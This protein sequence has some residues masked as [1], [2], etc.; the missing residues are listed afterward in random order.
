[1]PDKP[2]KP[3]KPKDKP[4]NPPGPTPTDTVYT[5]D[6]RLG[7]AGP[8]Q[9]GVMIERPLGTVTLQNPD[10]SVTSILGGGVGSK[11]PFQI[12]SDREQQLEQEIGDLKR[13]FNEQHKALLEEQKRSGETERRSQETQERAKKFQGTIEQ[14]QRKEALSFVLNRIRE[15]VH[16]IFL[17]SES[18]QAEFL[19]SKSACSAYVMAV[20][21]R[22]STELMLKS[23]RPELFAKF[24]TELS[25]KLRSIILKHNGVFDKFT[26]DGILAF[27]PTFFSGN[28]TG[29]YAVHAADECHRT[30]TEHYRSH[31][32]SFDTV[33]K[34]VGL[35]I[36][37]DFG[38]THL[39]R[40]EQ[41]LAIVGRPVVYACRMAGVGPGITLLNQPAYE[42][43][44]SKFSAYCS[45]EE[46]QI[47]VKHEGIH[48]GYSVKLNKKPFDPAQPEWLKYLAAPEAQKATPVPETP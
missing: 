20:D 26:G 3:D 19:S 35:G 7:V 41:E 12:K 13:Q 32:G 4:K 47:D 2:E 6:P 33:L 18:F 30:F 45:F 48:V 9:F 44:F 11:W 40:L 5:F 37:I 46:S 38:D 43:I 8:N 42:E 22:R 10:Y 29:Y 1:M 27:F 24:I 28:D 36:G 23:R 16:E 31:Y 34:D 14:L 25:T 21:L 15:D 39:V 17:G